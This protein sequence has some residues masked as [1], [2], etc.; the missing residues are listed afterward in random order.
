MNYEQNEEYRL[1]SQ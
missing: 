1:V